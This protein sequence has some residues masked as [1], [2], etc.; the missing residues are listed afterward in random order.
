MNPLRKLKSNLFSIFQ[1]VLIGMLLLLQLVFGAVMVWENVETCI[2]ELLGLPKKSE[3]LKFVGI[4]MGG[5][6]VA[7]QALMSYKR[8]KALE[9]TAR[10]QVNAADVQVKATEEQ[11]KANQHTEQGQRQ[12]RLKNAIEHL[13]NPSASVR[14]GGA[15]EL[16][17]LA[18][19]TEELRQT[20]LDILCA[21]I[22][23]TTGKKDYREN[24]RSKPSEEIQRLLTLLF[25]QKH[26]IFKGLYVDLQ[27][28]WL[29]GAN[30]KGACLD[31]ALLCGGYLK[32]AQF[33]WTQMKG[34]DLSK[35]NW[36]S[37]PLPA[38]FFARSEKILKK[39]SRTSDNEV[40]RNLSQ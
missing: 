31:E 5:G 18:Q 38:A 12:D 11:A 25:V 39:H 28:C 40:I 29:N 15:Y 16:F 22:H 4:G 35:A 26:D 17:H 10:A 3:I 30:F 13:G 9:D 33:L 6:L 20:I 23:G 7:L 2:A 34:A 19:D 36:F 24:H 14:L 1:Y 21:Y 32:R 8:A 27:E 37:N